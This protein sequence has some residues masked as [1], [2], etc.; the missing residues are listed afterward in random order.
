MR[1]K[2]KV[3]LI[4]GS[5]TLGSSIIKLKVFKNL[6]YPKKKKLDLLN[7]LSIRKYLA[8][9]YDIIINCAAIARMK[10]CETK[11]LKAIK[12]NIFGVLNLVNEVKNYET[13]NKKK[14]RLIHISTDGVYEST[15][16]NYTEN[17]IPKPYN[18]YSWT[19]LCSEELIK[20]LSNYIIIKARFFN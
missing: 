10:E 9:K 13:N 6:H 1:K 3:L 17:S 14:I 16:G 7:K 11:P 19:K 2:N 12:V 15:K 5:G 18:V 8:K 4:G 20:L